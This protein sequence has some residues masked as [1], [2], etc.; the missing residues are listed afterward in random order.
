MNL[1]R[2]ACFVTALALAALPGVSVAQYQHTVDPFWGS[3]GNKYRWEIGGGITQP[4]GK[5]TGV[6]SILG[7]GGAFRGDSTASRAIPASGFGGLI[8]INMP[9]K[10]TGHIS[11]WAVAAQLGVNMYTW[12]DL[13]QTMTVSGEYEPAKKSLNASTMQV[14]LPIGIDYKIGNDAILT[15]RLPFGISLGAGLIPQIMQTKLNE[16]SGFKPQWGYSCL[17]YAKFD[18]SVFTGFCWK[19][20][21]M[22]SMGNINL[23]DVNHKVEGYNDGMLTLSSSS[24]LMASFIIMPFSGGWREWAW[25]N[26]HDTYNIHDKFN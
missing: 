12:A 3:L 26:T 5:Y 9:F 25:Y 17:P 20:R 23:L 2:K 16:V 24:Q 15:K 10:G 11:C 18:V 1:I 19:I 22:Y 8:G 7:S 13:N 21:L 6:V 4:A 14:I